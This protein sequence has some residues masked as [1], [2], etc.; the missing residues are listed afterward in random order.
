MRSRPFAHGKDTLRAN[1]LGHP[2]ARFI[3]RLTDILFSLILIL[4]FSPL[5]L[6]AAI[7]VRLS[8]PGPVLFR[9]ERIGLSGRPFTIYKFRSMR[10]NDKEAS[11][12]TTAH[13]RRKTRFGNLLRKTSLDELPQLFNV[14]RGDM[15]LVGPRPEMTYFVER[16]RQSVPL[17]MLKHSVR[18]GITGLAQIMGLRGDTSIRRRI[19]ADIYYIEHWSLF[20]D[21]K[22]LILTP[23]RAFNKHE[24]EP[25]E[26]TR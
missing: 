8:S 14:L 3:K 16:F 10:V 9:Q 11:G 6:F 1:P 24:K 26:E 2:V 4:L 5:M 20:L 17:Y 7:G 13:D 21:I 25:K 15:S 22:I 23:F 18:P 12:W 19:R